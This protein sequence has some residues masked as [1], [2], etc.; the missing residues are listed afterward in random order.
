MGHAMCSLS[1]KPNFGKIYVHPWSFS[2]NV[3]LFRNESPL[4]FA[5]RHSNNFQFSIHIVKYL[6]SAIWGNN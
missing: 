2:Q 6:I 4:C 5:H 1:T 3:D